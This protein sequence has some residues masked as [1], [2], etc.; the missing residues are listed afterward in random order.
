MFRW[1]RPRPPSSTFTAL[2]FS[3]LTL[4]QWRESEVRVTFA[5]TLFA[6]G[7]GQDMLA[8]L[9]NT[10]PVPYLS[11]PEMAAIEAGRVRGYQQALAVLLAMTEPADTLFPEVPADYGV[12]DPEAG[13]M[14]PAAAPTPNP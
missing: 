1:L 7:L 13:S 2:P 3:R 12:E 5:R 6:Q 11:R 10:M 8:V 9:Q 4:P 14:A